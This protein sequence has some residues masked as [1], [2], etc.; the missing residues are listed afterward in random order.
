MAAT[1]LGA[2]FTQISLS[3]GLW[4]EVCVESFGKT[5]GP[6][7]RGFSAAET[8]VEGQSD[9][10]VRALVAHNNVANPP[11]K[12][13]MLQQQSCEPVQYRGESKLRENRHG[14]EIPSIVMLTAPA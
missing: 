14:H 13:R 8:I 11:L 3:A 7:N 10:R 2:L 12:L 5:R 9:E 1:S 6:L 4:D